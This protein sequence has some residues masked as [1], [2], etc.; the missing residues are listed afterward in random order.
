MHFYYYIPEDGD[1]SEDA[2][3]IDYSLVSWEEQGMD[4]DDW[5]IKLIAEEL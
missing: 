2:C 3:Y 4:D 1:D 5:E